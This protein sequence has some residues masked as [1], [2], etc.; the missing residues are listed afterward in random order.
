MNLPPP[1]GVGR[2]TFSGTF[3]GVSKWANVFHVY[4]AGIDAGNPTEVA[5]LLADL[6]DAFASGLFYAGQAGDFGSDLQ[7]LDVSDGTTGHVAM[8]TS[9]SLIG[10]DGSGDVIG[11]AAAVVSW[12]GDWH[13]RGGKP[14]TYVGGL[15]KDWMATPVLLDAGHISS[16][17][18]AA[19]ATLTLIQAL[20]G[21]YGSAVS[22]GALL[23][24][25]PT[26]PG[27][28][29]PFSGARVRQQVGSQ[30]RRNHPV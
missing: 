4:A 9:T 5:D 19:L 15:T 7:T 6:T 11:G 23:G 1:D 8:G 28:F 29:A 25:T 13:Y 21:S 20:S 2:L 3:D 16:L 22:L 14:R 10:S 12:L 26:S 30:R 27:T 24:N 17:H 18:D